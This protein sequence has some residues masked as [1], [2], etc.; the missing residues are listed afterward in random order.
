VPFWSRLDAI[1]VTL[2][3]TLG[4]DDDRT[5][6]LAVMRDAANRLDALSAR[7][8]KK[9]VVGEVGIRSAEGAARAP[10]E[11]AEEREANVALGLQAGVLT[12]WLKVLDRPSIRGILVWRWFTD[13]NAGGVRD[14]DFTVQNKP[15]ER[16]LMCAWTL[17]CTR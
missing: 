5:F 13:P 17:R 3:P 15:A 16:V 1:A 9:V 2:Y 4:R 14:T 12:D 8:Q 6:R 11:S 10:W 7:N